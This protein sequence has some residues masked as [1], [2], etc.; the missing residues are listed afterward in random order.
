MLRSLRFRV[1]LATVLAVALVVGIVGWRVVTGFATSELRA[2]NQRLVDRADQVAPEPSG[3]FPLPAPGAELDDRVQRALAGSGDVIRLVENGVVV[4]AAGEAKGVLGLPVRV[5]LG[6]SDHEVGGQMWRMY[7]I[8]A[9]TPLGAPDIGRQIQIATPL[10]PVRES[11][12]RL[13]SRV[14]TGGLA[15][16]VGAAVAGWLFGGVALRSLGRLRGTATQVSSTR[17]LSVRIPVGVGPAE[18]DELATSLNSM[19]AR[20]RAFQRRDRGR[21]RGHAT[22]RRRCRPRAAH[23]AHGDGRQPRDPAPQPGPG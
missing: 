22:V 17:D 23:A 18:V 2:V 3:S 12:N 21:A 9:A 6:L 8:S 20:L 1:A 15:A 7:A 14:V 4:G 13:S 11:I 16:L 10:A 19:L 5:P